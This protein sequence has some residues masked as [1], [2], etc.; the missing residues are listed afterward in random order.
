MHEQQQHL[1]GRRGMLFRP[2]H[3]D[4][5]SVQVTEYV[6]DFFNKKKEF[7]PSREEEKDKG[8]NNSNNFLVRT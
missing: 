1:K 3:I 8:H 6:D 4:W 2:A 7:L 5:E